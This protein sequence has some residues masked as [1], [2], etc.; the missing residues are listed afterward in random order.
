[1]SE[2]E[3]PRPSPA[4]EEAARIGALL[5]KFADDG[6]EE[7]L[8]DAFLRVLFT[9]A[10]SAAPGYESVWR[11]LRRELFDLHAIAN[12]GPTG[13]ENR[14]SREEARKIL[15]GLFRNEIQAD[16]VKTC[17]NAAILVGMRDKSVGSQ[18]KRAAHLAAQVL[19]AVY[20]SMGVEDER[21]GE[22]AIMKRWRRMKKD[23]K[24]NRRLND[25]SVDELR[26]RLH[27]RESGSKKG[28]KRGKE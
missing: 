8:R 26:H 27:P 18:E 2:S 14:F 11:D 10:L 16:R 9:S 1:M 28:P 22:E 24:A 13:P 12:S 6:N 21:L 15:A 5:K 3:S 7:H 17:V 25:L 20:E 19:P 23:A 4:E